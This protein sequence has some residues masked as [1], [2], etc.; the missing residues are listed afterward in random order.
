VSPDGGL[1]ASI[2]T[3]IDFEQSMALAAGMTAGEQIQVVGASRVFG[4]IDGNG[5]DSPFFNYPITLCIGCLTAPGC[6]GNQRP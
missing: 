6:F 4:E 5:V 3:L 1:T 2:Y